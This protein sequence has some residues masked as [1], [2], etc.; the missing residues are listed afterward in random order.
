MIDSAA[1][2][3]CEGLLKTLMQQARGVS[4]VDTSDQIFV[5]LDQFYCWT[6]TILP[7]LEKQYGVHFNDAR[8]YQ[9]KKECF[10]YCVRYGI[11][12]A[13]QW[14]AEHSPE[15]LNES[16][17]VYNESVTDFVFHVLSELKATELA[18][19]R[20]LKNYRLQ[21]ESVFDYFVKTKRIL[22]S[23][24]VVASKDAAALTPKES[25]E[26]N[27]CLLSVKDSI[28]KLLNHYHYLEPGAPTPAAVFLPALTTWVK[29]LHKQH[30]YEAAVTSFK[31]MLNAKTVLTKYEEV[32]PGDRT[33]LYGIYRYPV[34]NTDKQFTMLD[35]FALVWQALHDEACITVAQ[36]EGL[37][38]SWIEAMAGVMESY[39]LGHNPLVGF[40]NETYGCTN[41]MI[42]PTISLLSNYHP[43]VRVNYAND[44]SM[45]LKA[46]HDFLATFIEERWAQDVAIQQGVRSWVENSDTGIPESVFT[47]TLQA[48]LRTQLTNEYAGLVSDLEANIKTVLALLPYRGTLPRRVQ[49]LYMQGYIADY[50]QQMV[51]TPQ[52]LQ[53][54]RL[55]LAAKKLVGEVVTKWNACLTALRLQ[56]LPFNATSAEKTGY[57]AVECSVIQSYLFTRLGPP[58]PAP[59]RS[60]RLARSAQCKK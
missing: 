16:Y 44:A 34:P 48:Y 31:A 54:S 25:V 23:M 51:F 35:V 21:L 45:E 60:G 56:L 40:E 30:I 43:C 20:H 33:S 32:I 3:A 15:L 9:T 42:V 28:A 27:A 36:R 29:G 22:P 52:E 5:Q 2:K 38:E 49:K 58:P 39:E 1:W 12:G 4:L 57:A 24:L 37:L 14:F 55:A 13:V 7:E 19:T 11:L 17:G 8:F 41:A 59:I 53:K 47:P 18:Y 26:N 10:E 6:V 46:F 50:A